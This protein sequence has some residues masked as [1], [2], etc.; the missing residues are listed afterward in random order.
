MNFIKVVMCILPGS[1]FPLITFTYFYILDWSASKFC[2]LLKN[3]AT[4]NNFEKC[5]FRI[6]VGLKTLR[7]VLLNFKIFKHTFQKGMLPPK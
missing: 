7:N 1:G 6:R 4:E 5:C 3:A 2:I